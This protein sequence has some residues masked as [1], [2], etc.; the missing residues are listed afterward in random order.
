[1]TATIRLGVL[2]VAHGH[3]HSYLTI[4]RTLE[5]VQIAGVYD[6]DADRGQ[7]AADRHQTA[8]FADASALLDL[9]LDGVLVCAENA[10][11]AP[12]VLQAA[13][14]TGYILC[15][16]PI[17]TTSADALAMLERC[18]AAG[19]HLQIAFP[20]R[21]APP[22]QQL[23]AMLDAQE[24]GNV[25]AVKCTNHGG[26]PGGWFVD[27]ALSGG[28][29][30]MDHTVHV[31]DILRWF[32]QTDVEEVYAEIG[33]SLLHPDL[34]I[35]DV[36]LLSFRLR[37]GVYGT[38]DTSWSRPAAYPTW[39]DVKIEV[40][41]AKGTVTVDALRQALHVSSNVWGKSRSIPWG[42]DMDRGL[43]EDFVDMIRRQRPASIPGQDGLA[44][45][46][47]AL[48]AYESART[49]TPVILAPIDTTPLKK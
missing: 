41:G 5:Q 9:N 4:C 26:S 37:N 23:K 18:R 28:G 13:G 3:I 21:Y 25:Y 24:L 42:S 34:A 8:F 38:L 35:D 33:H 19:T 48:A 20:V 29:A 47:V 11:H 40:V 49:G 31:I 1:M 22:I 10:H 27:P 36:G 45:L 7:A 32:W 16:K 39:G 44:A 2:G 6:W 14:R 12:L 43:I 30:V 15:E 46:Q 17:A